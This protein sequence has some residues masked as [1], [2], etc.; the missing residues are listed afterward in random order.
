MARRDHVSVRRTAPSAASP[1]DRSHELFVRWIDLR[2]SD[3]S[4]ACRAWRRQWLHPRESVVGMMFGVCSVALGCVVFAVTLLGFFGYPSGHWS[5]KREVMRATGQF[6][7]RYDSAAGREITEPVLAPVRPIHIPT[8]ECRVLAFLAQVIAISGILLGWRQRR[9]S[10]LS[11][12]GF[13]L[14]MVTVAIQVTCEMTMYM[15]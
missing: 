4:A 12:L 14:V 9:V 13:A 1:Q 7:N 8:F 6:Q 11:T 15:R 3:Y 2:G 10:W 5:M